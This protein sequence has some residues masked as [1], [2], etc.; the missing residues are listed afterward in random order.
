M[1]KYFLSTVN[2]V[3]V[4]S[5]L[6]TEQATENFLRITQLQSWLGT[7]RRCISSIINQILF[8]KVSS[9]RWHL[10]VTLLVSWYVISL[11]L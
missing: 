2:T 8:E 1:V 10:I 6:V 3:L 11:Y 5:I 7:L 4:F 9:L